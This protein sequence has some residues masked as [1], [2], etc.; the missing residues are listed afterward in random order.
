MPKITT[1]TVLLVVLLM[2]CSSGEPEATTVDIETT[3]GD[4]ASGDQITALEAK[5]QSLEKNVVE[6][7]ATV[8]ALKESTDATIEEVRM[9]PAGE[10]GLQGETGPIG[11]TGPLDPSLVTWSSFSYCMG[12][13]AH[14]SPTLGGFAMPS[15]VMMPFG[16]P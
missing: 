5:V 6:L 15:Q 11:A 13:H 16:C 14:S 4:S 1:A 12:G 2:G 9:I 10:Q 7:S 8:S 3:V